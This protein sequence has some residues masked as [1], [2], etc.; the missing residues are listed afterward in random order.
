MGQMENMVD[1]IYQT[2]YY[3]VNQY[4][5]RDDPPSP[6]RIT[7]RCEGDKYPVHFAPY[8]SRLTGNRLTAEDGYTCEFYE[9]G[10]M[11]LD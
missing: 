11:L 3:V 9:Q 1:G 10:D 4:V 2:M 8:Y 7:I 6:M 5:I